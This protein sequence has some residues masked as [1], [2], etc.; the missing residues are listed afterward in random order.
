MTEI[1]RAHGFT[2]VFYIAERAQANVSA[3]ARQRMT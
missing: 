3:V 1:I 2:T